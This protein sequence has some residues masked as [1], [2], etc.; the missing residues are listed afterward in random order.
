LLDSLLNQVQGTESSITCR[1]ANEEPASTRLDKEGYRHK[2]IWPQ[3]VISVFV[4]RGFSLDVRG[5]E[6]EGLQSLCDNRQIFVGHGFS[7]A[8]KCPESVRL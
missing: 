5:F 6:E 4:G 7:R 1:P 2:R 8:V 3:E